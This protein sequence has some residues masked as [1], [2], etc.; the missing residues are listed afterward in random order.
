VSGAPE[1]L[2]DDRHEGATER[3]CDGVGYGRAHKGA[4]G[5]A[6]GQTLFV[7]FN[8]DVARLENDI[9]LILHLY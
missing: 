4:R 1:R 2:Y 5:G 6:H 8:R 7:L 9:L 3:L